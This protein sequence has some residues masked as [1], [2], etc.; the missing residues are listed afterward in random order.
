LSARLSQKAHPRCSWTR[1][2][3]NRSYERLS[4][5]MYLSKDYQYIFFENSSAEIADF[6][7]IVEWTGPTIL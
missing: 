3:V 2:L 7:Y 6:A 4:A 5:T 1:S